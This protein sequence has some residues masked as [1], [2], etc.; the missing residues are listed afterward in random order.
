LKFE[1][2]DLYTLWK[3]GHADS[4]DFNELWQKA[5]SIFI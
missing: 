4:F 2:Q 3:N 1:E 5:M